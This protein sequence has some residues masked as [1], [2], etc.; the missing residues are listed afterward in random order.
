MS[1]HSTD[2]DR[3]SDRETLRDLVMTTAHAL[4]RR[5]FGN[6]D[7]WGLSPHEVRALMV[8][9]RLGTP[10]LG[11]VARR[12]HIAPRSATEVIDRLDERGL[13]ERLPDEHDR[14]A[15]CVRTTE[16][17][18]HVLTEL[19]AAQGVGADD[20]FAVLSED[21]REQLAGLLRKLTDAQPPDDD[22]RHADLRGHRKHI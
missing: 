3:E 5:W 12:L 13:T 10:R 18:R 1:D 17:G 11:E 19:R 2:A 6:L 21:E 9:D 8:V 20:Y 14:R 22:H 16:S 7:P 4:R 15:R